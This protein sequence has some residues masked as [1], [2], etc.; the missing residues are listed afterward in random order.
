VEGRERRK[1]EGIEGRGTKVLIFRI[2]DQQG[3]EFFGNI[4]YFPPHVQNRCSR[5]YL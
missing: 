1:E 3:F 5:S 4:G 2:E